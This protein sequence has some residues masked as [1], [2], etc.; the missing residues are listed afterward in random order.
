ADPGGT[1]GKINSVFASNPD[2]L[3]PYLKR[4]ALLDDGSIR[5]YFSEPMDSLSLFQEANFLLDNLGG[6]F[7]QV[8]PQPPGYSSVWLKPVQAFADTSIHRIAI[9]GGVTDCAG[10]QILEEKI[11]RVAK[12]SRA[13]S[14]DLIIDEVLFDP[15]EG[16]VAY[17]ELL[18][19]SKKVLDV[20]TLTIA[21][22]DPDTDEI[23]KESTV[24]SEGFLLFPKEYLVLSESQ[25]MVKKQYL[26]ENADA[27]LDVADMPSLYV[28]GGAVMI[29]RTSD[30]S[31]MEKIFYHPEMQFSLLNRIDG[32]AL[33]R[34]SY[35]RP[36]V[37]PTNWHSAAA[38]VG[39][40]TPGYKNSIYYYDLKMT[41]EINI[42]PTIFSPNGDGYHEYATL[43]ISFN[44]PG[45]VVNVYLYNSKGQFVRHLIK[46]ILTGANCTFIWDGTDE[47]G[48][49]CDIGLYVFYIEIFN[50]VISKKHIFKKSVILSDVF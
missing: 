3:R 10:N 36:G 34:I 20:S 28:G 5:V 38:T 25:E 39:F 6:D 9:A 50:D 13:D 37:D 21:S 17:V 26:T 45:Y 35:Y 27:F 7:S 15:L 14:G 44:L 41:T 32:V 2:T 18:N 4:A 19:M 33:E 46:N 16:G 29:S 11:L 1:P 8:V 43:Q 40:G 49:K 24:S 22:V 23:Q 42:I 12:P 31:C 47:E 48:R 30:R